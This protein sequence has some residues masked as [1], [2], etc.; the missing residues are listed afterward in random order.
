MN[1]RLYIGT[2]GWSYDDWWGIVYPASAKRKGFDELLYLARYFN[3]AE[4]N[5]TFYRIPNLRLIYSWL[6]RTEKHQDFRFSVKLYQGFTHNRETLDNEEVNAFRRAVQP[7]MEYGRLG[8]IL[9]QF[10]WSFKYSEESR[11]WLGRIVEHFESFPL[12]VEVRHS[13]WLCR[14]YFDFLTQHD[15]S[16]VSIDQP[17][18][19]QSIKPSDFYAFNRKAYFRLHGRN[20]TM[21]FKEEA[22]RDERYNYLYS[23]DELAEWV[24]RVRNAEKTCDEVYIV[25]NN[26]FAG[27]AVANALQV[28]AALTGETFDLPSTLVGTYPALSSLAKPAP[29]EAHQKDLFS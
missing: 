13:S 5:T 20:R 12:A 7:L 8:V 11:A 19:G 18:F 26:H 3:L 4:I 22:G 25:F 1:S 29:P 16:F 24:P 6:R 23:E 14:E 2:A 17:I 21:W 15:I 28:K 10:P 27:K 9:I